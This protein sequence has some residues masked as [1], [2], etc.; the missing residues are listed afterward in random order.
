MS[1][2][3]RPVNT[4]ALGPNSDSHTAEGQF[5]RRVQGIDAVFL[6]G[7]ARNNPTQSPSHASPALRSHR[8]E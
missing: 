7:L 5:E 3:L 1:A 6:L 8:P 4:A 2:E